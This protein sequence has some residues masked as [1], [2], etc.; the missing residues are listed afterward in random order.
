MLAIPGAKA[1]TQKNQ[2]SIQSGAKASTMKDINACG[3]KASTWK[4][5]K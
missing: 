3:E 4:H 5:K 2:L 1:P